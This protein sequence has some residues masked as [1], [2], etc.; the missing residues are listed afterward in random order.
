MKSKK[1]WH[2][3]N[4]AQ[5][6]QINLQLY[7]EQVEQQHL[8]TAGM[9]GKN[10]PSGRVGGAVGAKNGGPPTAAGQRNV[11]PS[12]ADGFCTPALVQPRRLECFSTKDNSEA[13]APA[14]SVRVPVEPIQVGLAPSLSKRALCRGRT[15]E[16]FVVPASSIIMELQPTGTPVAAVFSAASGPSPAGGR[17]SCSFQCDQHQR[18]CCNEGS[19]QLPPAPVPSALPIS[20]QAQPCHITE[21]VVSSA[22][23]HLKNFF[24]SLKDQ[25]A[26]AAGNQDE[27]VAVA[28]GPVWGTG[29]ANDCSAPDVVEGFQDF[30][31]DSAST[32]TPRK[33][34]RKPSFSFALSR[35]G[36]TTARRL[37]MKQK[38]RVVAIVPRTCDD[39]SMY[40]SSDMSCRSSTGPT[41]S[42]SNRQRRGSNRQRRGFNLNCSR[43][44][45]R[46]VLQKMGS[47]EVAFEVESATPGGDKDGAQD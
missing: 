33:T 25:K 37:A 22:A 26:P 30:E 35:D 23:P 16:N 15:N 4:T 14:E 29:T 3:Y 20:T 40:N 41:W 34:T 47:S 11:K 9:K 21:K 5:Q 45:A 1:Y 44:G 7:R 36:P 38:D 10:L 6:L 28:V 19:P 8:S 27:R 18:R 43:S 2:Q 31:R 32:H 39:S 42:P 17:S 24:P 13:A 46:K 12:S